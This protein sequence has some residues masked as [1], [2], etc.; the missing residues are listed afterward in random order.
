MDEAQILATAL[1]KVNV[2]D[3]LGALKKIRAVELCVR[4]ALLAAAERVNRGVEAG[5]RFKDLLAAEAGVQ[6]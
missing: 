3:I 1:C 4:L 5:G 2:T 6:F